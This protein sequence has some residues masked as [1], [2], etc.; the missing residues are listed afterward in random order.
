MEFISVALVVALV[1]VVWLNYQERK[2]LINML[3]AKDRKDFFALEK[4][5]DTPKEVISKPLSDEI[6]AQIEELRS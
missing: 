5:D 2:T 6:E 3:V 1:V 4:K